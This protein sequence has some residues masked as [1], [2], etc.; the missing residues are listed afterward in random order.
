MGSMITRVALRGVLIVVG[1]TLLA[2]C[3]GIAPNSLAMV[4]RILGSQLIP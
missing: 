2:V 1:V 4:K 3:E